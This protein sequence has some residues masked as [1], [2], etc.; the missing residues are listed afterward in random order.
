MHLGATRLRGCPPF[1]PSAAASYRHRY[2]IHRDGKLHHLEIFQRA[3]TSLSDFVH[4]CYC[5]AEYEMEPKIAPAIAWRSSHAL[6]KL[7]GCTTNQPHAACHQFSG[8]MKLMEPSFSQ[9]LYASTRVPSIIWTNME[10]YFLGGHTI[11]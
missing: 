10:M 7:C 1:L 11:N 3:Q 5:S 9:L 2:I 8:A 4:I 6:V